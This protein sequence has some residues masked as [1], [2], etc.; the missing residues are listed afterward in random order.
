[1]Q[2]RITGTKTSRLNIKSTKFVKT[3][4]I[5]SVMLGKYIFFIKSLVAVTDTTPSKRAEVKN[6]HGR[7]ADNKNNGYL[8]ILNLMNFENTKLKINIVNMGFNKNH[9][10]PNAESLYFAFKLR[11]VRL[12]TISI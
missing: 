4:D 9:K 1:L 5:G 12:N 10:N 7:I 2:T 8:S 11:L 3:D 6:D